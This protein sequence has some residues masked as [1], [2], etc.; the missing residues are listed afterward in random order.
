MKKKLLI[1]AGVLAGGY[2]GAGVVAKRHSE[3]PSIDFNNPY[4]KGSGSTPDINRQSAEEDE[5][6]VGEITV[7]EKT[8]KPVLDKVLSFGGLV[9][10]SPVFLVVSAVIVL[11][12]PGPVLFVQKRVG[13]D[14][15]FFYLHKFRTMKMETPSDVPTH[16]LTN[17][18]TYITRVGRVLRRTSLDELPQ[19]WDIWRG[20]MSVIGPRPALWNQSDLIQARG[21]ANSAMP[22]LTGYAQ[23]KG[24]DELE[25]SVKAEFDKM[26][27]RLLRSSSLKGLAID[28]KCFIGT[29]T[30]VLR[31]DGVVEGG[32]GAMGSGS[33]AANHSTDSGL[34]D[35]RGSKAVDSLSTP[36]ESQGN[37]E[38]GSS[39]SITASNRFNHQSVGDKKDFKLRPG[40]P[41]VDPE[42]DWGYLK[43]FSIDTTKPVRV[44]IT[45][46]G[47]YIGTS[48]EEYCRSN[49]PN[50][51]IATLDMKGISWKESPLWNQDFDTVFHVA[52]IAHADVGKASAEE[53]ER[54]YAINTDLA[55]EC[56]RKSRDAGIKQFIFMSSMIIYGDQSVNGVSERTRSNPANFY[57]DS[58]WQAD[59][60]IRS[61]SSP[62]FA[63][64]VLRPP[65]IYGRGSKGNYPTLATIAKKSPIFPSVSNRKSMLYIENLC[66]FVALLT[67][68][69]E[70]GVY[71]PQNSTYSNTS[72][73]VAMIASVAGKKIRVSKLLSLAVKV[74]GLV[75]G[76]IG[77]LV[78]KAFGS[79]W[80]DQ[81]LS[82]YTGLD[83]QK[84]SL[85]ESIRRTEG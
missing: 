35:E 48:F 64:A 25:I 30:S 49:Y 24:R 38:R 74:G 59:K 5:P 37:A 1:A 22:G 8:I 3:D 50:I 69:G 10:L 51:E 29:I 62:E 9:V 77:D 6:S 84:V 31:H 19:I 39:G 57:G 21:V 60:G 15:T 33:Q 72:S 81:S 63:V 66:E 34:G 27:V 11:D 82:V 76:K 44:L 71:V 68:S 70:S 12:D 58:K 41:S 65:M 79:S 14:K 13:K 17:P 75:P 56:A 26:Y 36:T 54:Y 85:E 43:S 78:H 46:A 2:I 7:Y 40:V 18:E 52:G 67:L 16:L 23:I 55:I 32:T 4:I 80:Y 47:G 20:K 53:I 42:T 45:G 28:I 83:Y 73:L 61:L